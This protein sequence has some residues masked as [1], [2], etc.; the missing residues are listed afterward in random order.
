MRF[1]GFELKSYF[2]FHEK[3]IVARYFCR[4]SHLSKGTG[5]DSLRI[6][7]WL[8]LKNPKQ[9]GTGLETGTCFSLFETTSI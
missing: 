3:E 8:S 2:S 4:N 6:N 5:D 7:E 9:N 1:K